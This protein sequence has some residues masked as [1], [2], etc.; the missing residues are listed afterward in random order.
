MAPFF[1][2]FAIGF[3]LTEATDKS[4]SK[5]ALEAKI[6]SLFSKSAII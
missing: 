6:I 1:Y 3:F 5:L 4:K 2:G